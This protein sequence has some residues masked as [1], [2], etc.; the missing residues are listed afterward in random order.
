MHDAVSKLPC[1]ATT[2]SFGMPAALSS[3]SMFW[4]KHRASIPACFVIQ[5]DVLLPGEG[6]FLGDE[7]FPPQQHTTGPHPSHGAI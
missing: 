3:E 2:L 4:V 5:H 1:A 6:L 7:L